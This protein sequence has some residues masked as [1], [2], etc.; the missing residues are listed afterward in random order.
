MPERGPRPGQAT[1]PR[2]PGGWLTRS[3]KT[4]RDSRARLGPCAPGP[5]GDTRTERRLGPILDRCRFPLRRGTLRSP[6]TAAQ[7]ARLQAV[8][9]ADRP[10]T[11]RGVVAV[12]KDYEV[13]ANR[14]CI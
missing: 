14:R 13:K 2:H 1:A 11:A 7:T 5:R 8:T 12:L 4:N 6:V 10:K 9:S 3:A